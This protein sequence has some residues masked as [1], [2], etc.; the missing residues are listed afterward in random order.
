MSFTSD[1]TRN[2]QNQSHLPKFSH[3]PHPPTPAS[4]TL[5]LAATSALCPAT[6]PSVWW[7]WA[8]SCTTWRSKRRPSRRSGE[9]QS[10][11]SR[12]YTVCM[13]MYMYGGRRGDEMNNQRLSNLQCTRRRP[14]STTACIYYK[15][16]NYDALKFNDFLKTCIITFLYHNDLQVN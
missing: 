10:W 5:P 9:R 7:R 4:G 13:Y 3:P 11:A 8:A 1:C 6:A 2:N 12:V 14:A 15:S 16:R